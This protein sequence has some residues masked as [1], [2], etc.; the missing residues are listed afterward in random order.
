MWSDSEQQL[1]WGT[2]SDTT[3][4]NCPL[5]SPNPQNQHWWNLLTVF[6]HLEQSFIYFVI[7]R[8]SD[9]SPLHQKRITQRRTVLF[10]QKQTFFLILFK[11]GHIFLQHLSVRNGMPFYHFILLFSLKTGTGGIIFTSTSTLLSP[12]T[13]CVNG[14]SPQKKDNCKIHP[15]IPPNKYQ[16]DD[17][18]YQTN[19]IIVSNIIRIYRIWY[20]WLSHPFAPF[21][22]C[23]CLWSP[24]NPPKK[25]TQTLP[26]KE[27]AW[28]RPMATNQ[29]PLINANKEANSVLSSSS[30]Q[31]WSLPSGDRQGCTNVPNVGPL[32]EIPIESPYNYRRYGLGFF[33]PKK[34][35]GWTW[36]SS[37]FPR[38][39]TFESWVP[40]IPWKL[41]NQK[42]DGCSTTTFNQRQLQFPLAAPNP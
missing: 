16:E 33:I 22:V 11:S 5:K 13:I 37:R 29:P 24:Q 25:P 38:I 41:R 6:V 2:P 14:N 35:R 28:Q 17:K 32:S 10:P 3:L 7:W 18:N 1:A 15:N 40:R 8:I 34:S 12:S 31:N 21:F 23:K 30:C 36:N 26:N 27:T 42:T 39:F 4:E 9:P 20:G 19:G